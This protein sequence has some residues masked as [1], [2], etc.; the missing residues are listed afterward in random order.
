V[1]PP[2]RHP[3]KCVNDHPSPVTLESTHPSLFPFKSNPHSHLP[4]PQ[5]LAMET[6]PPIDLKCPPPGGIYITKARLR[7]LRFIRAYI[8]VHGVAP[9]YGIMMNGLG[10]RTKSNMHRIVEDL[11]K[12]GYLEKVPK[13]FLGIKLK[14]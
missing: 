1:N 4:S 12:G 3:P 5:P 14:C 11:V 2:H 6:P 13:K 10:M 8:A 9:S 7:V